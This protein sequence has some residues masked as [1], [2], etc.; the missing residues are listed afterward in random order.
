MSELAVAHDG[1][2]QHG[3]ANFGEAA[4]IERHVF[5][6]QVVHGDGAPGEG[7]TVDA[8]AEVER[9]ERSAA[10]VG[11]HRGTAQIGRRCPGVVPGRGATAHQPGLLAGEG[12]SGQRWGAKH[13]GGQPLVA[14]GGSRGDDGVVERI[15]GLVTRH[16]GV[17][18]GETVEAVEGV[19]EVRGHDSGQAQIPQTVVQRS[20]GRAVGVGELDDHLAACGE[21]ELDVKHVSGAGGRR[22][23]H[24]GGVADGPGRR[25]RDLTRGG[26]GGAVEVEQLRVAGAA[27]DVT[28]AQQDA[29]QKDL[30]VLGAD[31]DAL[32]LSGGVADRGDGTVAPDVRGQAGLID[33]QGDRRGIGGVEVDDGVLDGDGE[34]QD[35]GHDGFSFWG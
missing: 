20:A 22:G 10:V 14:L 2:P 16:A 26:V 33:G 21:A 8:V 35:G 18:H 1:R 30:Q 23:D 4:A 9:Q 29:Q 32:D 6:T 3:A 13:V 19:D 25:G 28:H 27:K 31:V 11:D 34:A 15:A 17:L 7:G 5:A 12:D 24:H